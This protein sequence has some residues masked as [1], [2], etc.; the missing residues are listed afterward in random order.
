MFVYLLRN[1]FCLKSC[2]VGEQSITFDKG[3]LLFYSATSKDFPV[4]HM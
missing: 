3:Q 4:A 1:N 2:H